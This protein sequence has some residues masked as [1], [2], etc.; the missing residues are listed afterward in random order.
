M[1]RLKGTLAQ[2]AWLIRTRGREWRA[3][4]DTSPIEELDHSRPE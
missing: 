4:N 1:N 2:K 3:V